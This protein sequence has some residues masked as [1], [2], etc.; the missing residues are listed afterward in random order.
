VRQLEK[1]QLVGV[2]QVRE[3]PEELRPFLNLQAK[4]ENRQLKMSDKVVMLQVVG[5]ASFIA[6]FLDTT[7]SVAELE[8][9]LQK[10]DT[11]MTEITKMTIER[12]LEE[13]KSA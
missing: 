5:T 10:Q 4:G 1:A 11:E 8:D 13:R 9:R 3:I 12:L 2:Y 6:V 7:G